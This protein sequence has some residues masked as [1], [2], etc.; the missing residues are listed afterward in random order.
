MR[1]GNVRGQQSYALQRPFIENRVICLWLSTT[2]RE[3]PREFSGGTSEAYIKK[4]GLNSGFSGLRDE[5]DRTLRTADRI[6]FEFMNLHS[7]HL[8]GTLRIHDSGSSLFRRI[9]LGHR[10]IANFTHRPETDRSSRKELKPESHREQ[11]R[12]KRISIDQFTRK[13]TLVKTEC[14]RRVASMR[15]GPL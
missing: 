8:T 2:D 14:L 4:A 3:R 9:R 13:E 12:T 6:D 5:T 15:P 10:P 11:I 7:G 1:R